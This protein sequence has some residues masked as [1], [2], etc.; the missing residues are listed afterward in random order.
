MKDAPPALTSIKSQPS[1]A[2]PDS[3]VI[4][5]GALPM[6]LPQ[7]LSGVRLGHDCLGGAGGQHDDTSTR[8]GSWASLGGEILAARGLLRWFII[9]F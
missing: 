6:G 2:Q 7:R 9:G 8:R 4:A 3:G 1:T 5:M